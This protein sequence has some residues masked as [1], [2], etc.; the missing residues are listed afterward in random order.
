MSVQNIL[1]LVF[2]KFADQ[3]RKRQES[4]KREKVKE[5]AKKIEKPRCVKNSGGVEA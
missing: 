1:P 5:K 2:D 3:V 4:K